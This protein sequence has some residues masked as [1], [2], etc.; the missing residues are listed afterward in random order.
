MTIAP[1]PL[2]PTTYYGPNGVVLAGGSVVNY[3]PNTTMRKFL[4]GNPQQTGGIL[5]NPFT[6]PANGTATFYGFGASRQI[7]KDSN[8][9]T[10]TDSVT[11]GGQINQTTIVL[12]KADGGVFYVPPGVYSLYVEAVGGGGAG[13]NCLAPTAVFDVSGGG[14][15]AGGF[16]NGFYAVTPGQPISYTVGA[17]GAASSQGPGL[18]TSFGDFVVCTGGLGSSFSHQGTSAGGTGGTATGGTIMN[19][20]G[21]NGTDGSHIPPSGGVSYIGPGNGGTSF[22]GQ[23]G[24]SANGSSGNS[25]TAPGSGGGGVMDVN[26]LGTGFNGGDGADGQIIISYW[27]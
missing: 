6:L 23:G 1:L 17:G 2:G 21:G 19:I 12:A 8:G 3:T 11:F 16:A 13:S 24:T 7:V 9:D 27:S 18:G 20:S 14:G 4:W 15:G 10:I 5:P 22:Y 26:L 25:G